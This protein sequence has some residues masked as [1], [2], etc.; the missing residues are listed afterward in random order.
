MRGSLRL[1]AVRLLIRVHEAIAE[2]RGEIQH[3][4][5]AMRQHNRIMALRRQME[6]AARSGKMGI[7]DDDFPK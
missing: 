1:K 3:D 5:R 2:L 6:A 4:A 7:S